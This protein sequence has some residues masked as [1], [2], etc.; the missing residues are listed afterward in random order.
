MEYYDIYLSL[1]RQKF[2]VIYN[3]KLSQSFLRLRK[4]L[5]Q[6]CFLLLI[7]WGYSQPFKRQFHKMVKHTQTICQQ[8]GDEFFEWVWPFCGIGA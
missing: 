6:K 5:L 2:C 7:G 4:I 1:L 3:I 8:F